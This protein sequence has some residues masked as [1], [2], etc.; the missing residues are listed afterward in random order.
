[1]RLTLDTV[2]FKSN[3]PILDKV[4]KPEVNLNEL[5]YEFEFGKVYHLASEIHWDA[6][7]LSLLIAGVI[8]EQSGNIKLND[9]TCPPRQRQKMSWR[10][11]R[12]EVM[13]FGLFMQ[14]VKNQIRAGIKRGNRY[15]LSEEDYIQYFKLTPQ[16]YTRYLGQQSTEAWRSSCAIGLAH[17]KQI[18]CFPPFEHNR[19]NVVSTGFVEEHGV[20]WFFDML[21]FMKSLNCL[22]LLPLPMDMDTSHFCDAVIKV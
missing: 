5:S 20:R 1:M 10:V 11:H 2:K 4:S 12:D 3:L 9:A 17:D 15:P 14:S 6:W 22:I 16:R 8:A 21:N 13:R 7:A 19:K 18:F